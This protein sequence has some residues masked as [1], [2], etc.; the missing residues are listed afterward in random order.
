VIR[1]EVWDVAVDADGHTQKYLVVSSAAW[2]DGGLP[3]CVP[4]LRGHNAPEVI[5]FIVLTNEADPV[6]GA[7]ELGGLGPV[8][9]AA[10]VQPSGMLTGATMAKVSD[11]LRNLYEL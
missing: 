10:F 9:P 6:T 8:E 1:G 7:L 5:P 4:V 11:C 2:N 3:Q